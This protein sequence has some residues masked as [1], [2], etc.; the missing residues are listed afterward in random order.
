MNPTGTEHGYIEL[1]LA[2][3]LM[4]FFCQQQLG[5][6]LAGEFGLEIYHEEDQ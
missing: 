2:Y 6:V 5:R 3:E 4:T 1:S